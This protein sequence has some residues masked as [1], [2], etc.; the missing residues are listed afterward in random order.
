MHFRRTD[1][2]RPIFIIKCLS[3]FDRDIQSEASELNLITVA[4]I[5]KV[6]VF[7]EKPKNQV[8]TNGSKICFML[9]DLAP[10]AVQRQKQH[11]R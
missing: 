5:S 6:G 7:V 8:K 2:Y 1:N 11:V 4:C 10:R 9:K 3:N